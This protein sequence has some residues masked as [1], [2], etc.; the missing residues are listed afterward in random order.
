MDYTDDLPQLVDDQSFVKLLGD[1]HTNTYDLLVFLLYSQIGYELNRTLAKL[2]KL[3]ERE[4]IIGAMVAM[5]NTQLLRG[6]TC[7][8][9]QL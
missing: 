2:E 7:L 8:V 1:D 5:V 6:G 9:I 4:L 3:T